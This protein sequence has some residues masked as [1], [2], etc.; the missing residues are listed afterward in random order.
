MPT[1]HPSADSPVNNQG[2]AV[3]SCADNSSTR[4]RTT[5]TPAPGCNGFSPCF[6]YTVDLR[7]EAI[8]VSGLAAPP[9]RRFFGRLCRKAQPVADFRNFSC[10]EEQVDCIGSADW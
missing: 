1:R 9:F 2:E 6:S 8:N 10:R 3:P 7:R 4:L 5:G